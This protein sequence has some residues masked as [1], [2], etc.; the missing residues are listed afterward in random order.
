MTTVANLLARKREL[1][2]RLAVENPGPQAR[3]EI[4]R[5][6]ADANRYSAGLAR[7][8]RTGRTRSTRGM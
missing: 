1:L 6:A 7:R 3:D 4:D 5:A 2:E 8:D